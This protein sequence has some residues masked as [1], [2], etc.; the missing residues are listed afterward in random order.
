[1]VL[2]KEMYMSKKYNWDHLGGKVPLGK[3]QR[4]MCQCVVRICMNWKIRWAIVS[5]SIPKPAIFKEHVVVQEPLVAKPVHLISCSS[6]FQPVWHDDHSLFGFVFKLL[7]TNSYYCLFVKKRM[8]I[9]HGVF[10]LHVVGFFLAC[11]CSNG[12][13]PAPFLKQLYNFVQPP[14]TISS[15]AHAAPV[16][17]R[18][19]AIYRAE[20]STATGRGSDA[21]CG[22]K[23]ISWMNTGR[24]PQIHA[25]AKPEQI[26]CEIR[27]KKTYELHETNSINVTEVNINMCCWCF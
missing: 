20:Q 6:M 24:D 13:Q 25:L 19:Q 26:K 15:S 18:P 1:M 14:G 27:K 21:S 3:S 11:C 22:S 9:D 10:V 2:L 7:G 12:C 23:K 16:L 17:Q 5:S 4:P 8:M